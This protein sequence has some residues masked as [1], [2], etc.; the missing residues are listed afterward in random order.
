MQQRQS[1]GWK[2]WDYVAHDCLHT[3]GQENQCSRLE[4]NQIP[5]RATSHPQQTHEPAMHCS[6]ILPGV[7][8]DCVQ[9]VCNGQ[10]GAI[11]KLCPDGHLDEVIS[12]QVDGGRGLVQDQDPGFAQ[13]S[14]GQAHELPLANT[15]GTDRLHCPQLPLLTDTCAQQVTQKNLKYFT[16]CLVCQPQSSHVRAAACQH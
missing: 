13:E 7:I 15:A 10:H 3:A 1:Q 8:H 6:D 4:T 11:L 16:C 9:P 5:P 14:S 2:F 12:L